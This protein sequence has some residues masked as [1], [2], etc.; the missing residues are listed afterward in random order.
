HTEIGSHHALSTD[1]L[2]KPQNVLAFTEAVEEYGH[3]A[4]IQSMRAQPH[5]VRIDARE[6]VHH[7]PQ[8]LCS[9]RDLESQQLL[10]GQDIAQIVSHRA[11]V[12]DAIC[13]RYNLVIELCLASLLNPS[14]Q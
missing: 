14:V 8:P 7:H 4:K 5:Q 12:I 10:D 11:Q 1:C 6:F 3:R 13:E 2:E 9:R